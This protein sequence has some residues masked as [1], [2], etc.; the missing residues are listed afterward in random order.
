MKLARRHKKQQLQ[1]KIF[2]YSHGARWTFS[3]H[4]IPAGRRTGYTWPSYSPR[5]SSLVRPHLWLF[6]VCNLLTAFRYISVIWSFSRLL[7]QSSIAPKSPTS[8]L[9]RCPERWNTIPGNAFRNIPLRNFVD[10]A[11][12]LHFSWLGS[13]CRWAIQQRLLS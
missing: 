4:R 1:R 10:T 11:T 8:L 12:L 13:D 6:S 5:L 2:I 7:F 3:M 9:D